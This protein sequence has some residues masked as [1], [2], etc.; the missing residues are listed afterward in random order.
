MKY[1]CIYFIDHRWHIVGGQKDIGVVKIINFI[2]REETTRKI[3]N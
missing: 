1:I 2:S 3:V